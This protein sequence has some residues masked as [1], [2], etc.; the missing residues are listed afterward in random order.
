MLNG[1]KNFAIS[2]VVR[3]VA[4]NS[5]LNATTNGLAIA[6]ILYAALQAN[7]NWMLMF[8]CCAAPGSLQEIV[9]VAAA[10]IVALLLFLCGKFPGLKQW[11][12]VAQEIIT[13][14]QKEAAAPPAAKKE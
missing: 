6:T 5:R 4:D 1:I 11:L 8:Q 12:P 14:A 7:A 2:K 3:H 13:E 10:I 9:R